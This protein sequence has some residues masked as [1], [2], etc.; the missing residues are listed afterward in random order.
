MEGVYD[1]IQEEAYPRE[2]EKVEKEPEG[3]LGQDL[4]ETYRSFAASPWGARIG[5]FLGTVRKQGESVINEARHEAVQ[6]SEDVWKGFSELRTTLTTHARTMSGGAADMLSPTSAAAAAAASGYGVIAND[7]EPRSSATAEEKS[8]AIA[9][10]ANA[11]GT[12]APPPTAALPPDTQGSSS[13][14]ATES[15]GFIS[16]FRAEAEKRLKDIQKAEDAADEALLQF[17]TNIRNFLRDAVTVAPP[18]ESDAGTPGDSSSKVLFES[19]DA[20]G[21]KVIHTSRF[22]A[23]LHVIHC[24]LE[25]FTHD[26]SS[27]EWPKWKEEFKAEAKTDAIATDLEKYEDLRRAMEKLVPE[28]VDYETFWSRYYFLRMVIES[29]EKRRK[30]MLKGEDRTSPSEFV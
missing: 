16:R 29:E 13:Q 21:R 24:A 14:A 3:N 26:P 30:E 23:Q 27:P 8:G 10:T 7:D 18:S 20:E 11:D 1:H 5:G 28:Q 19:K 12:T 25:S 6:A 2:D 4:Q 15:E 22:D 9:T 17:G